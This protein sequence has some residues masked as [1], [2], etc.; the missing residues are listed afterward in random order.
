[1]NLI[2]STSKFEQLREVTASEMASVDG[3]NKANI[4]SVVLGIVGNFF[5]DD[6][7]KGPWLVDVVRE[8]AG[9]KGVRF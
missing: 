6:V 3:G 4:I 1:M 7:K 2:N 9:S 5:Y 8:A